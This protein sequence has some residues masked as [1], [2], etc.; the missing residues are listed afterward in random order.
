V[1]N[2]PNLRQLQQKV[3]ELRTK[4]THTNPQA[5]AERVGA[6]WLSY[7]ENH[8]ELRLPVWGR[9]VAITWPG[10]VASN[11]QTGQELGVDVQALLFYHFT[12]SDGSP[13]AEQW[14]SFSELPDG[15]FYNKAF[16]GYTGNELVRAL[17]SNFETFVHAAESLG[18][19]RLPLGD[20]SFSFRALPKVALLVVFWRGDE[21]FPASIQILFDANAGRHLSTDVCAI[22]GSMLTRRLIKAAA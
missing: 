21:D 11:Q 15:R 8:G 7:S 3:N 22:L 12:T 13:L 10:L 16:Q 19:L 9:L 2:Q 1:T 18:G 14:I 17:N 6:E 5:L 4:I 20:V